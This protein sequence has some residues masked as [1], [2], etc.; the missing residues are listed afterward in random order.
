L[1]ARPS[2]CISIDGYTLVTNQI[3]I[4]AEILIP[5]S[6]AAP[7]YQYPRIFEEQLCNGKDKQLSASPATIEGGTWVSDNPNLQVDPA[8]A[9][10]RDTWHHVAFV[11]DSDEDRIYLDGIEEGVLD[12]IGDPGIANATSGVMAIGAVQYT[13]GGTPDA[14]FIG[15]IQWLRV[16]CV[17]RYSGAVVDPPAI[18]P[19]VD[20]YTQILFDFRQVA[21][22]A[23]TVDDLSPNHFVGTVATGFDD[24]TAPVFV[25]PAP[26]TFQT[27]TPANN[28]LTLTWATVAGLTYQLQYATSLSQPAWNN[29]GYP[30]VATNGIIS[31]SAPITADPQRF[32][33][34]V[35]TP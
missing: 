20:A 21:L 8:V 15:A 33:R 9:V 30:L 11:H 10:S 31:V 16:S 7:S 12:F 32:Y 5:S 34:V 22:G 27:V 26:P 24:A 25:P 2:D 1:F 4:E 28:S 18:M 3:T 6:L 35:Q 29:M 14:S 23:S 17:A 13:C 19:A